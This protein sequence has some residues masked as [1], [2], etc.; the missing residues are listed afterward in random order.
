[1]SEAIIAKKKRETTTI[2]MQP[3]LSKSLNY[4][5]S[6]VFCMP[7]NV[8]DNSINVTLVGTRDTNNI[9]NSISK[10]VVL[11][12]GESVPIYISNQ[13]NSI[14]S[15]G[16]YIAT[17]EVSTNADSNKTLGGYAIINYNIFEEVEQ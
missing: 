16:S 10:E 13:K 2:I 1:M 17:N 9:E 12:P 11:E 3:V 14:I 6:A 7:S 4:T 5:E 15:F 8:I